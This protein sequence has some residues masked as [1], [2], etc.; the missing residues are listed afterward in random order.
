MLGE[1]VYDQARGVSNRADYKAESPSGSSHETTKVAHK[2][3][4]KE[5]ENASAHSGQQNGE[6]EAD[7]QRV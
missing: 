6:G 7:G 4:N 5:E 1:S 3:E 2:E